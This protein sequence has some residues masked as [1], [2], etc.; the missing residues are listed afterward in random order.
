MADSS[1]QDCS[2]SSSSMSVSLQ[3]NQSSS[4]V[5]SHSCGSM[6]VPASLSSHQ[7]MES[8][9]RPLHPS[10]VESM[11]TR[12]MA[13]SSNCTASSGMSSSSKASL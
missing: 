12:T 9:G 1:T 8:L 2:S 13:A 11:D 10:S 4:D 7:S 3:L 5:E 6:S